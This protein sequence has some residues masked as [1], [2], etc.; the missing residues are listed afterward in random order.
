MHIQ[1]Q[2]CYLRINRIITGFSED[3]EINVCLEAEVHGITSKIDMSVC[4]A[5]KHS[6]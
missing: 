6:E 3:S 2:I 4:A 5:P 1:A